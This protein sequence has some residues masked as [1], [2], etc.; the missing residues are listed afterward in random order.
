[1]DDLVM[2]V[3]L[4]IFFCLKFSVQGSLVCGHNMVVLQG[5]ISFLIDAR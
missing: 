3:S 1:M 2:D 4:S 5:K